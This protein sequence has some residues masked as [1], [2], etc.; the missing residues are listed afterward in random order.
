MSKYLLPKGSTTSTS[1]AIQSDLDVT[2]LVDIGFLSGTGEVHVQPSSTTD[3]IGVRIFGGVATAGFGG[4]IKLQTGSGTSGYGT[5]RLNVDGGN[6]I[7]GTA[8]HT[9]SIDYDAIYLSGVSN[10]AI[11]VLSSASNQPGRELSL[12]SGIGGAASTGPGGTGGRIV[13]QGATGGAGS[14]SFIAGAGGLVELRAG[15]AGANGGSGGNNGGAIAI[16]AGIATGAGTNGA[17][18]IG[19]NNASA[20]TLGRAGA[21]TSLNGS[22]ITLTPSAAP[23]LVLSQISSTIEAQVSSLRLFNMDGA[24]NI[25]VGNATGN[26]NLRAEN[27]I[28]TVDT[29]AQLSVAGI[30]AISTNGGQSVFG[31]TGNSQTFIRSG[32]SGI[33]IQ[34]NSTTNYVNV[35][36][37]GTTTQFVGA[38]GAPGTSV[39]IVG[40]NGNG[41]GANAGA[42]TVQGGQGAGGSGGTAGGNGGAITIATTSGGAGTAS[43][44]GGNS[45]AITI[46]TATGGSDGGFGGGASGNIGIQP[47]IGRN[48]TATSNG[49]NGGTINLGG[50]ATGGNSGGASSIAGYGGYTNIGTGTGGNGSSSQPGASGGY[51]TVAVGAGGGGGGAGGGTAGP[52]GP[53]DMQS[54]SGGTN[55]GFGSATGGYVRIRSHQGSNANGTSPGG[56]SG[57]I[58]INCYQG[59]SGNATAAAGDGG[60]IVLGGGN[61]GAAG[62][63]VGGSGGGTYLA[64]GNGTGSG[65]NGSVYVGT[66][67]GG[68]YYDVIIS[69]VNKTFSVNTTTIN[70]GNA[71]ATTIALGNVATT[72]LTIT[73]SVAGN[74]SFKKE[75]AHTI[76]VANSTGSNVAG[77]AL[78]LLAG[79]ATSGNANGGALTLDAGAKV[80]TGTSGVISIG[81]S[82]ASAI[83]IGRA[84]ITT[85]VSGTLL[86][87][88]PTQ[89]YGNIELGDTSGD[90]IYFTGT[91]TTALAGNQN[92]GS[93]SVAQAG[94]DTSSNQFSISS[95][96]GGNA[97]AA[98]AGNGGLLNFIAGSGGNGT[99]AFNPGRGGHTVVKAGDAGTGGTGNA[100]GGDLTLDAGAKSGTGTG[101]ALALGASNAASVTIGR[102]A[103]AT[104]IIFGTGGRLT[105]EASDIVRLTQGTNTTTGADLRVR[106]LRFYDNASPTST[107]THYLYCIDGSQLGVSAT[108]WGFEV[109]NIYTTGQFTS[110]YTGGQDLRLY[111]AAPSE[112]RINATNDGSDSKSIL[113]GTKV[114]GADSTYRSGIKQ[115]H[116]HAAT[117]GSNGI[118]DSSYKLESTDSTSITGTLIGLNIDV[119]LGTNTGKERIATRKKAH[120]AY[121]GSEVNETTAAIQTTDATQTTLWSKA[122]ADTT[123]YWVEVSVIGRDTA[124]TERAMY[125]KKV[126]VY[127]EGGGA[128]IQGTVQ[129]V[130]ADVETSAGID[131]T[132]TVSGNNVRV[133][134][135]GLAA[136][137]F[138]W[139][140]TIKY[141]AVSGN[142]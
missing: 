93:I 28:S 110:W 107:V 137:T 37:S 124:G 27:L 56:A 38:A 31:D 138:N 84:G 100:N 120:A 39:S 82:S 89:L 2:R 119:G 24:G 29:L 113:F 94:A 71:N 54:G 11:I 130:H 74:L 79:N 88:G 35:S 20:T 141:Q 7:L 115:V 41:T 16:D 91:A 5:M 108:N 4:Q 50:N 86:S 101:G 53:I 48:G 131:V 8:G 69:G 114:Q 96:Y 44:V 70:I 36:L 47:G 30:L 43:A 99:G 21:P 59:G 112:I 64:A 105:N 132:F 116:T 97:S 12:V 122:L 106:K 51:F 118:V 75:S 57:N 65:I 83:N 104:D 111:T 15:D 140:A 129:D 6:A 55:T 128:T 52:G 73:A 103:G 135:T 1:I 117:T 126:L 121:A 60:F 22:T 58:Y 33:A 127:R 17:I 102:S 34:A 10:H 81:T 95:G 14:G 66:D 42:A 19:A 76:A 45:G 90:L 87:N 142:T 67:G 32:S 92:F 72:D 123:L 85:A 109:S 134:V 26:L 136:T 61:A 80:G 125:G 68:A 23:A 133:S 40:G 63:G 25:T 3:G 13:V 46:S 78:S 9:I 139:V 77:G 62:G 49:Q 98:N 18:A